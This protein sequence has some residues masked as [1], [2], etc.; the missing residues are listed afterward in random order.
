MSDA[1]D[2]SFNDDFST[3]DFS[4]TMDGFMSGNLG[5]T[6]YGD[7]DEAEFADAEAD[8]F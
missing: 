2:V 1:M 3:L 4:A 6:T 7:V 8:S 5:A